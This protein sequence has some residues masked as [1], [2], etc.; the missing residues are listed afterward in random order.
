MESS[1][2]LSHYRL[3]EK[4]GEGGMGVVWKAQDTVLSRTVAVKVLPA[5]LSRDER[6]RA[7]FLEEARLASQVSHAH[8]VQVHEF[9]REGDL[10]F[11]VMEYVEGKPLSSIM[12]G[13]P[14]DADRIATI[15]LQ[16]AQ[17]LAGAH[18]KG[19][20]HRDIKPSNILVTADGE[21]KVVDF[22]LA[23]LS[24][25]PIESRL[26]EMPTQPP[27]DRALVGPSTAGRGAL[28]GTLPYMS[29]EQARGE[30]L[31]SR[32]DIFSLGVVLYEMTTGRRPFSGATASDTIHDILE[33]APKPVHEIQKKV[34]LDLERIVQKALAKRRSDRYQTMDDLAVDLRALARD[35]E[36]GSSPSYDDIRGSAAPVQFGSFQARITMVAVGVAVIAGLAWWFFPS[37]A[38]LDAKTVLVLPFEVRG[39][40]EGAAYV[41]RAFA[42][43]VATNLARAKSIRVLPVPAMEGGSADAQAE[44]NH[45]ARALGAGRVVAGAVTR[46]DATVLATLSLIDVGENRILWGG[47]GSSGEGDLPTLAASLARDVAREIGVEPLKLYASVW[48]MTGGPAMAKSVLTSAVLGALR[49]G[50]DAASVGAAGRL[51]EAFPGEIDALALR[52]VALA[53]ALS[54]GGGPRAELRRQYSGALADLQRADPNNPYL[55]ITRAQLEVAFEERPAGA[56]ERLTRLLDRS[57]LTAAVRAL[58]LRRRG[59][60]RTNLGDGAGAVQDLEEA[61]SLSPSDATIFDALARALR[62]MNRN[63][64]ALERA[65]QATALAPRDWKYVHTLGLVLTDLGRTDEALQAAAR[66]CEMS[67]AQQPCSGYASAL[68][69]AGRKDEANKV[70]REA[71]ALPETP[72]GTYNLACFLASTGHRAEA[73]TYLHRALSLGWTD[74]YITRDPDLASL[75]DDP[76]FKAIVAEVERRIAERSAGS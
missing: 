16:V 72:I 57:D 34:P 46:N 58:V 52:T 5:D 31:D 61:R 69:V 10:D 59:A 60:A 14:L 40:T 8:V 45:A 39:Q 4:L 38:S 13:A 42:E 20:L 6:R 66:A 21:I 44:R 7:M 3:L 70:F 65:Q 36:S 12:R 48:E 30:E 49:S 71:T 51:V 37:H 68:Y 29:P 55:E 18:R 2:T 54:S 32:S 76:D 41:G 75:R 43:S 73:L 56:A 64:E 25:G 19:L 17:A 67:R 33:S 53:G 50:D 15:G 11:I 27:E 22:G 26:S 47:N 35:L 9:G 24:Q 63:E 28:A 1:Q 74:A 23:V 62:I